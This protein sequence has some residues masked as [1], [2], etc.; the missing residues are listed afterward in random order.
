MI[1][2]FSLIVITSAMLV[3]CSNQPKVVEVPVYSCPAPAPV[4]EPI[5]ETN[6]ITEQS[7]MAQVLRAYGRDVPILKSYANTLRD[8]LRIYEKLAKE[9]PAKALEGSTK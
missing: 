9:N 2:R 3:A 7:S 6:H 8:Q 4:T 5:L 1:K